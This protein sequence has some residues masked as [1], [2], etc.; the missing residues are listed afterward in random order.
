MT[1]GI[2]IEERDSRK[3]NCLFQ[4]FCPHSIPHTYRIRNTYDDRDQWS[5]C[6]PSD[7]PK[8]SPIFCPNTKLHHLFLRTNPAHNAQ[9]INPTVQFINNLIHKIVTST[10]TVGFLRTMIHHRHVRVLGLSRSHHCGSRI[11]R[12][13]IQSPSDVVMQPCTCRSTNID[14]AGGRESFDIASKV[15]LRV[16]VPSLHTGTQGQHAMFIEAFTNFHGLTVMTEEFWG[17]VHPN[18]C[19]SK[20]C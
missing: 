17:K 2:R 11:A 8:P 3:V 15:G 18:G 16:Y 9:I 1:W 14:N 6:V 10:T 4:N 19:L 12:A 7:P 20:A 5:P 13:R